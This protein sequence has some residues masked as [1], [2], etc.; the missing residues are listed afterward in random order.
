MGNFISFDDEEDAGQG[1]KREL[2]FSDLLATDK[3]TLAAFLRQQEEE[4][5]LR[6]ASPEDETFTVIL[7]LPSKGT[8]QL[9]V[10]SSDGSYS[11]IKRITFGRGVRKDA[12]IREALV[13]LTRIAQERDAKQALADRL[14]LEAQIHAG[15]A[16]RRVAALFEAPTPDLARSCECRGKAVQR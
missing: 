5:A 10:R 8:E 4:R 14:K 1:K 6:Q 2:N 15:E 9:L 3:K 7:R 16:Q 11:L 13:A 12:A